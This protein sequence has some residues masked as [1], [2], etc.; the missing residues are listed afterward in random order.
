MN[1]TES[2]RLPMRYQINTQTSTHEYGEC[3]I[4]DNKSERIPKMR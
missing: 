4:N 1:D 3:K 2:I